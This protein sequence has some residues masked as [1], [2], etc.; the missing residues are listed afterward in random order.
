MHT[1]A[2][3]VV[4]KKLVRF[5][6]VALLLI[7]SQMMPAHALNRLALVIGNSDYKIQPLDNPANDATAIA[8]KL[9]GMGFT[10]SRHLDL[11]RDEIGLAIEDF[12][13]TVSPGDEIVFFYAGHG[14][15]L[16]GSNYLLA[17]DAV[18]RTGADVARN[19][20]SVSDLLERLD[21]TRAAVKL[22]FLDA[23]RN[24]P[25]AGTVRG[26]GSSRGL[27]Q[28]G[29]APSGTLISFATQPGGVADDG[30]GTHGLYTE[31]L[32][33]HIGTPGLPIE[34]TLKRVARS[35]FTRSSG[36]QRPWVEGSL[37]G[38]FVFAPATSATVAPTTSK[39]A[40]VSDEDQA[41]K[42]VMQSSAVEVVQSFLREFPD[43]RRAPL[44]R[45]KLSMLTAKS[46]FTDKESA[47]PPV[48]TSA[49]QP[50]AQVDNNPT[51]NIATVTQG[52]APA[53]VKQPAPTAEPTTP[54]PALTSATALT[55]ETIGTRFSASQGIYEIIVRWTGQALA[56]E[57]FYADYRKLDPGWDTNNY[58]CKRLF[59]DNE[60]PVTMTDGKAT[61]S[62]WCSDSDAPNN[63]IVGTFPN[64]DII[65]D[66][67]YGSEKGL[68]F[69]PIP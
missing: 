2:T 22:V 29:G 40:P 48:R 8:K 53:I 55:K 58:Q 6:F 68:V 62:R 20:I 4:L 21:Q 50:P 41:W 37:F 52:V 63:R 46:D 9:S 1:E 23:C 34:Q 7:V 64:F 38:D 51:V 12:V 25:F 19:S 42:M 16:N 15:Q 35:T 66:G 14:V 56:I 31:Q 24:N 54:A 65:S 5:G 45:V 61:F 67:D 10:V 11:K 44:A 26:A 36:R 3:V 33:A 47:T 49:Q 13:S 32:L 28:I 39:A 59:G 17:T 18:I 43:S 27:A 69:K 30:E 60:L 57:K